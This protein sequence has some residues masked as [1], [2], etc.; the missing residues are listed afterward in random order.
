MALTGYQAV[1]SMSIMTTGVAEGDGGVTTLGYAL[2]GL[3]ARRALSG[4]DLA[5]EMRRPVG[6]FWQARH[7]QIYPQLARLEGL[8][9]VAHEVVAQ[10]DRPAKKVY[11]ITATGRAAL[12]E[13][14]TSEL[15]DPPVRDELVLR[16]YSVWLADPRAAGALF[17][18][19]AGRREAQLAH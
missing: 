6:Y 18:E 15:D 9:L 19:H 8:G 11:A 7:S 17:R 14:V 4:Y 13:W 1:T 5:R 2:L 12:Q 3:L 10:H 16:A